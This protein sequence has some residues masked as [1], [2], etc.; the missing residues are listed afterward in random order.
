MAYVMLYGVGWTQRWQIAEGAIG[1]IKSEIDRVG[2]DDTGHLAILDPSTSEPTT[3]VVSWKHVA[4]AVV[5]GG[6]RDE[7]EDPT[8][9]YR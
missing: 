6:E 2:R 8:G 5:L 9:P 4:A 3:L 1:S 7:P